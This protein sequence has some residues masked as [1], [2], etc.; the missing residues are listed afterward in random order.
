M[1][2]NSLTGHGA[3]ATRSSGDFNEPFHPI[4]A[5]RPFLEMDG[6]SDSLVDE[7]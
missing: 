2:V 7:K 4:P 6:S 3:A 5:Y 1:M